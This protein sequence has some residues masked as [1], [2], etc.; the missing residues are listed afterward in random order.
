MRVLVLNGSLQGDS[1]V[2]PVHD[3]V[4]EELKAK[5]WEVEAVVLRDIEI[6]HCLGCFKCWTKT[7]GVCSI[8]DAARDVAKKVVQSDLLLMVTPVT[9][10]G[11]S[12][13]LKKAIDRCIP[14]IS[15]FF[16]K[17]DGEVHHKPRYKKYPSLLGIG[18]LVAEDMQSENVFKALVSRHAINMHSP[19]WD[20]EVVANDEKQ[21]H[22][23]EKI[24]ALLAKAG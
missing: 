19:Y 2:G 3:I 21:D 18:V 4:I 5:G 22:V 11:Y 12:S 1:F 6:S 8:D 13:E 17:V 16:M 24:N 9:F 10:G 15:P 14:I 20:A 7:P 23:R